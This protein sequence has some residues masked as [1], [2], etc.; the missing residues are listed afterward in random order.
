MKPPKFAR[1]ALVMALLFAFFHLAYAAALFTVHD[2]AARQQKVV[3]SRQCLPFILDLGLVA[4]L[5]FVGLLAGRLKR[6][7]VNK[8][9]YSFQCSRLRQHAI[10]C[11]VVAMLLGLYIFRAYDSPQYAPLL[12][13]HV[14][15]GVIFPLLGLYCQKHFTPL[16]EEEKRYEA[17][18]H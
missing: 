10:L 14:F 2:D 12:R 3:T 15:M 1:L 18:F 17:L 7:L 13:R 16:E 4:G 8:E 5:Y 9:R 11:A 6:D